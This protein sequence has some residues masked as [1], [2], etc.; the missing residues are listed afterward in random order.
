MGMAKTKCSPKP[1]TKTFKF[2][3]VIKGCPIDMGLGPGV[4][5]ACSAEFTD[6]KG[7][8][9]NHPMFQLALQEKAEEIMK[10]SITVL[11]DDGKKWSKN[12]MKI[13]KSKIVACRFPHKTSKS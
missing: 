8:S 9:F 7:R 2:Y 5:N 12:P 6:L 11:V 1:K 3:T 13:P 4:V 10:R